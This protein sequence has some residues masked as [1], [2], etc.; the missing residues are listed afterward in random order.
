MDYQVGDWVVHCN[1]GLGRVLA[2]EE[3]TNNDQT[4]LYY[5]VQ[6]TDLTIWVPADENQDKR[7]RLPTSKTEFDRLLS[8]LSG[9]AEQLLTDRRQRNLQLLEMLKDG[10]VE[11][12]CRVLRNLSAHRQHRSWSEYDSALLKRVQKALIGEW[13]FVSSITPLDAEVE[14][15]HLLSAGKTN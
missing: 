11:S 9:P 8:T 1:H 3:R 7:L 2:I 10:T 4:I 6:L 12:L 13:S 5:K 15:Q 14:L